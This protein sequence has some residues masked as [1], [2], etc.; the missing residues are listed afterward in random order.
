MT[1]QLILLIGFCGAIITYFAGKILP[2]LREIFAVA[3]SLLLV[4]MIVYA[5]GRYSQ[6]IA[7][8]GFLNF[9]IVFT[10]NRLSWLFAIIISSLSA[11]S[12]IFSLSYMK[13]KERQ[14]FFYMMM[15]FV[16]TSMLGIVFSGTFLQ[17]FIFWEI[18]SWSTFLLISYSK[19]KAVKAGLKY[20]TMSIIGSMAMLVAVISLYLKFGTLEISVI[21][22]NIDIASLRYLSCIFG[23]LFL[24]FGVK[25]AVVPLHTWLPDAHSEA[26]SPFSAIL[27]G[28]LIK[29]GIYG[30]ILMMYMVVGIK[31]FMTLGVGWMK[32]HYVFAWLGVISILIPSF[33]A[34]LQNDAKRLL[35]WSSVGQIG[36]II[37]GI[38]M[39]TGLGFLGG[40]F[41]IF[42]HAVF[43]GLLFLTIASVEYRTRTRD[44]DQ[45][46][47]LIKKM[48]ITF[49]GGLIGVM[50]L[51]GI[52]LTNGF[53][54][55]W[56]IYKSLFES[57]RMFL[58]LFSLIGTWAAILYGYKILHNVFLGQLPEKYRNMKREPVFMQIP[59]IILSL[60]V[61]L[62][63]IFPGIILKLIN[64]IAF[65]FGLE[66]LNVN[67]WGVVSET[68]TLNIRN[69]FFGILA[70]IALVS[71]IF[72]SAKRSWK[73]SQDD[74]YA[75]GAFVPVEKYNYTV[76]FYAPLYKM[77]RKYLKDV[78][79]IFYCWI[80]GLVDAL[81]NGIR[82][83]YTG[84]IGTYVGYILFFL[85]FL[86]II[87]L[88]G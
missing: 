8:F 16:S 84:D 88:R 72:Y 35:A 77:I 74:N 59:I 7:Q 86:I 54:S 46:G 2:V 41:H 20:I 33:I 44:L 25:A 40:T 43:K 66:S 56:L 34:I 10:L 83:I 12:I 76:E 87:Y 39:G 75:A 70:A 21:S 37:V 42:S 65:S 51:I 26:P 11:L 19:G 64:N 80:A 55:K 31:I 18:M 63:G 1:L 36:Y 14:D 81:C 23:L 58:L 71:I 9:K 6:E 69:I 13:G 27:S 38:S 29:M 22:Q 32:F 52:P 53:I 47:G 60:T 57:N 48:P 4:G 78:I 85:A 67:M 79:D 24:G 61:I 3:I 30:F 49:L 50:G 82:K 73:V 62:S 17:L 28:I 68:G 15:L 5:Y 45:L